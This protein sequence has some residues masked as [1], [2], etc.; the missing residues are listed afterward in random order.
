MTRVTRLLP[1]D[2]MRAPFLVQRAKEERVIIPGNDG[3][4]VQEW[5]ANMLPSAN[6]GP[7]RWAISSMALEDPASVRH[8]DLST[9]V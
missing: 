4:E 9:D 5:G 7:E 3:K 6:A 1:C 8:P 2:V